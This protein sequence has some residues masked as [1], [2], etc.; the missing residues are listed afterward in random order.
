[1]TS[2]N[3]PMG[4]SGCPSLYKEKEARKAHK[5]SSAIS[6]GFPGFPPLYKGRKPGHPETRGREEG[7]SASRSPGRRS[8]ILNEL[9]TLLARGY[10]RLKFAEHPSNVRASSSTRSE[11]EP[12]SPNCLDVAGGAERELGQGVQHETS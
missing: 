10:L 8:N 12:G 5:R 6:G 2:N 9:A 11:S 4:V 1:M 3:G 7:P